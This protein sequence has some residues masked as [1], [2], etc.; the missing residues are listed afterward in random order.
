MTMTTTTAGPPMSFCRTV[1][2]KA[3]RADDGAGSGDG[4]TL[5]GYA[6]VFDQETTID[7]WEGQ[8]IETIRRGAFKKTIRE[9]TPVLQFDH[10]RHP[11]VGSIPIGAITD[12]REDDAGL[13]VAS[14]LADNWLIEPV[15][16]AIANESINGMSFRFEVVRQEWTDNAGKKITDPDELWRLMWD[17]GDRGPL[18]RT[19]IELKVPELG[20]VVFPAY[21]GTSVSVRAAGI[22]DTI[23]SDAELRREVISALAAGQTPGDGLPKDPA[24]RREV[25]RAVLFPQTTPAAPPTHPTEDTDPEGSR[26]TTEDEPPTEGHPSEDPDAP[27]TEGHPSLSGSDRRA[28]YARQA[29][30]TQ[31][32]VGRKYR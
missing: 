4:L 7:S 27:P 21:A 13:W 32:S 9:R 12:L 3:S 2:F 10:G 17:A 14:R 15:R 26:D 23:T 8:F 22:A 18:T 19:L 6:A 25:A 24:L 11:L 29:Y 31:H 1:T 28:A 20:P 5:N 16:D 30:V